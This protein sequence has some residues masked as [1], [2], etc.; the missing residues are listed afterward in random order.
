MQGVTVM[1]FHSNKHNLSVH[2]VCN[3]DILLQQLLQWKLIFG[4]KQH[5][6]E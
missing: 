4:M 1:N 6:K 5:M 3:A 2:K